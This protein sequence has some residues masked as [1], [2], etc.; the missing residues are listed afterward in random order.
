MKT[1]WL[2]T[3]LDKPWL[4]I[5]LCLAI[6]IVSTIGAKNLYFRGDYKVFFEESNPQRMAFEEMQ[7]VFTKSENNSIIIA[8]KSG[9]VFTPTTLTLVKELTE[10]AWQTPYSIRVDSIANFQHTWSEEDDLIVE[11]LV[12]EYVELDEE[13]I[14]RVKGVALGEP[15]LVG[16]LISAS[17]DVTVVNIT[18]RLPDGDQ[19][20]EVFEITEYVNAL[21]DKFAESYPEHEFYHTGMVQLNNAFAASAKRDSETL[22]PAMFLVIMLVMWLLLRTISATLVTMVIIIMTI[23]ATIGFSGWMGMFLSTATVNV[24]TIVMTLAVADCIHVIS[25]MLYGVRRGKSKREALQHSLQLNLLPV[26]ITSVTTAI[27]FLTLNFAEVPILADLGNLSALGVML[28]CVFSLTLLPAMLMVTPMKQGQV[29]NEGDLTTTMENFGEWVITHHRKILPFSMVI[30]V[31]AAVYT[32]FNRLNDVPVEYFDTSN[33]F[34][35][36][37]DFQETHLSGMSSIDIALFTGSESGIN[38]PAFIAL[39]DEFAKWLRAQPEVDHVISISDTFKR[40]NKNMHGDDES[41]YRLP[42][43][44][45]LAAQYLL[46]YE[47]SLPFGLDLNNQLDIDK[48]AT[49]LVATLKNLGSQEF[50]GFESRARQWVAEKA[51]DVRFSAASPPLMFAHIG[52]ANMAALIKGAVVALAL[53]SALLVLALRSFK[54]G[55]V[56]LVPNLLP[57]VV[58]FGIWGLIS[59]EVN[60]ALSVVL[61]MT[62]GIIVDDTVHFLAKYKHAREEGQSP[63]DA[64]RYVFSS[65]GKALCITTLVLTLGFATLTLSDF[66][67]NSDMG[68]LTSIIIAVALA[69]D[70]LFLPAFLLLL[71]KK[72]SS[73][74]DSH[75]PVATQN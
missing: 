9:N 26:V 17:G 40:L 58:G 75:A 38:D 72:S 42:D 63:E 41:Y 54:L 21:T 32:S 18:V 64:I 22:I 15:D 35:Q 34:R 51:P 37:A 62:L 3:V 50:T 57:A 66:A 70:F 44:R 48:S 47:M 6:A 23:A 8:P 61:S 43:D 29:S 46:L 56:S 59:A 69:V 4:T 68:L 36:A 30:L 73:Q 74:G 25:T 52:E 71:D 28:A 1:L 49:R 19:T 65:V 55:V 45:E 53:I 14:E 5:L 20:Q 67:L 16:R 31:I 60:M 11:D 39:T 24:P 33:E 13:N 12:S 7:D 10:E 27:G 2:R